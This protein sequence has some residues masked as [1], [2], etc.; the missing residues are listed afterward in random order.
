MDDIADTIQSEADKARLKSEIAQL[1]RDLAAITK[2]LA[3][4]GSRVFD[5]LTEDED[6]NYST[7]RT[8][9][10]RGARAASAIGHQAKR[11]GDIPTQNSISTLV[12]IAGLGVI[13]GMLAR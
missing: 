11:V 4:K 6:V 7:A 8:I 12:M 2:T 10:R 1:K 3:D 9:G 5:D 13:I